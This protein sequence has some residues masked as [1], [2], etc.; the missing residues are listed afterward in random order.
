MRPPRRLIA[1]VDLTLEISEPRIV[2]R[3]AWVADWL[4]RVARAI[5][6]GDLPRDVKPGPMG[7]DRG[8]P[9]NPIS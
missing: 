1:R 5:E 4:R 6:R 7:T 3:A 2:A 8:G 9:A